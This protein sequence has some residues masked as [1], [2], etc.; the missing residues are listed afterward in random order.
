M[1]LVAA[2]VVL[3]AIPVFEVLR[4]RH[5]KLDYLALFNLLFW[6]AYALPAALAAAS[7]ELVS[8][9]YGGLPRHPAFL[10]VILEIALAYAAVCVGYYFCGAGRIASQWR[11]VPRTRSSHVVVVVLLLVG[12]AAVFIYVHQYGGLV[13]AIAQ[14]A[15]IRANAVEG[16]KGVFVKPFIPNVNYAFLMSWALLLWFPRR[17][18]YSALLFV[19]GLTATILSFL[20]MS[21]RGAVISLGIM[22]YWLLVMRTNR[23]HF[24]IVLVGAVMGAMVIIFGDTLFASASQLGSDGPSVVETFN[25]RRVAKG[26]DDTLTVY[27]RE[28][29]FYVASLAGANRW[30]NDPE[31]SLRWFVDVPLGLMSYLPERLLGFQVP[32]TI[33][34]YNTDQLIGVFESLIPP[35]FIALGVYSLGWGGC[36]VVGWLFGWCGRFLETFFGHGARRDPR[37]ATMFVAWGVAWGYGW[38]PGEP[39]VFFQGFFALIVLTVVWIFVIGRLAW[40]MHPSAPESSTR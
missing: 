40:R 33:A 18:P 8:A 7:P 17:R 28:F 31:S 25:E 39:R 15:L 34:F 23:W 29:S 27:M 1:D 19:V 24:K 35:G 6:V 20:L 11:V 26:I 9:E 38:L 30:L 32:P 16:G 2:L 13:L 5:G 37:A 14:S 22:S 21:G 4:P 36:L 10:V 12:G 3:I